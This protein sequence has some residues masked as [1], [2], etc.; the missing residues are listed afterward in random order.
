[1]LAIQIL[2]SSS[3]SHYKDHN[4]NCLQFYLGFLR[5]QKMVNLN[6]R[7]ERLLLE[8]RRSIYSVE[9]VVIF[10]IVEMLYLVSACTISYKNTRLESFLVVSTRNFRTYFVSIN[11]E[12]ESKKL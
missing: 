9:S 3:V 11:K 12:R 6:Q 10:S 4:R 2:P 1:M 7:I 5:D 8:H